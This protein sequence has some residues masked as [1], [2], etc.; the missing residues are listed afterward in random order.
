MHFE[1]CDVETWNC[2]RTASRDKNKNHPN[3]VNYAEFLNFLRCT[4]DTCSVEFAAELSVL[5]SGPIANT[6]I[7][8]SSIS[9]LIIELVWSKG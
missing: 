4:A 3:F 7:I 9:V 2:L 5:V 6:D 1:Q 8:F